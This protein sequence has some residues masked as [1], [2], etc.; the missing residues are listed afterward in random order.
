[1]SSLTYVVVFF[2]FTVVCSIEKAEPTKS[3][4]NISWLSTLLC[5]SSRANDGDLGTEYLRSVEFPQTECELGTCR[6]SQACWRRMRQAFVFCNERGRGIFFPPSEQTGGGS[7]STIHLLLVACSCIMR[8]LG[9]VLAE[10][11]AK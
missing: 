9:I 11:Q 6:I 8:I 7:I 1:M 5:S 3:V 10:A 2:A 4:M